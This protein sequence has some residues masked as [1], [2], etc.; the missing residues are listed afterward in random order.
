MAE[1]PTC[2]EWPQRVRESGEKGT[3]RN[4]EEDI[5]QI[6]EAGYSA[7][8]DTIPHGIQEPNTSGVITSCDEAYENMTGHKKGELAEKMIR[9]LRNVK[10]GSTLPT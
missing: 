6:A 4:R 10:Q 7:L 9:D 5:I 8:F 2:E 1:T 3:K